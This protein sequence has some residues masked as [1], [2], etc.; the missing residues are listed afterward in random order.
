MGEPTETIGQ[1]EEP[2]ANI[3]R[4]EAKVKLAEK[5]LEE[6]LRAMRFWSRFVIGGEVLTLFDAEELERTGLFDP[7]VLAVP[8]RYGPRYRDDVG[9]W[10]A[11]IARVTQNSRFVIEAADV[12]SN[13]RGYEAAE[14][15]GKLAT[16]AEGAIRAQNQLRWM[17]LAFGE[18]TDLEIDLY[19]AEAQRLYD[20]YLSKCKFF[21]SW[22]VVDFISA[23]HTYESRLVA[24]RL[25]NDIFHKLKDE[26]RDDA[27]STIENIGVLHALL[28]PRKYLF[29]AIKRGWGSKIKDDTSLM[30]TASVVKFFGK[31]HGETVT[32]A[33]LFSRIHNYGIKGPITYGQ[34]RMLLH[35]RNV[36]EIGELA[37]R[38]SE[39]MAAEY[40]VRAKGIEDRKEMF[41]SYVRHAVISVVGSKDKAKEANSVSIIGGIVGQ[42]LLDRARTEFRTEHK[43]ILP[44]MLKKLPDYLKAAFVLA[45]AV[46]R[47]EQKRKEA[48]EAK[49][50]KKRRSSIPEVFNRLL[51][52]TNKAYLA[53]L[54]GISA[55]ET[56]NPLKF[57][58]DVQKCCAYLPY[59]EDIIKYSTNDRCV[60][61][62]YEA[63]VL[64]NKPLEV[65]S[66]ICYLD[67]GRF[68]VDSV[69]GTGAFID[70]DI[71]KVVFEDMKVRAAAHGAEVLLFGKN[72]ANKTPRAFINYLRSQ[73]LRE[74]RVSMDLPKKRSELYLETKKDSLAFALRLDGEHKTLQTAIVPVIR[75]AQQKVYNSG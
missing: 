31:Q 29:G 22:R 53:D 34:L 26:E 47:R 61:V 13:Y 63:L 11:Y 16:T 8:L 60:L 23:R 57:N 40:P 75:S 49:E 70:P 68:L 7:Q 5:H 15:A 46:E 67:R 43:D 14:I 44:K 73:G 74:E 59:K 19:K 37:S 20:D 17:S 9:Y 30:I 45:S 28:V 65:G 4:A 55:Y 32:Q 12:I 39:S 1:N 36:D 21:S 50:R 35:S 64:R 10:L 25:A 33:D 51:F 2:L 3:E 54:H 48:N 18:R 42:S 52:L 62:R 56:K 38:S 71:F 6:K 58:N 66:A 27:I 69:E 41:E 72:G 24:V